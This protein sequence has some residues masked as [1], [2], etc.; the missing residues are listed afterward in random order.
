[1]GMATTCRSGT[2][3]Q[4]NISSP[5]KANQLPVPAITSHRLHGHPMANALRSPLIKQ[6]RSGMLPQN[7]CYSPIQLV[8]LH[9]LLMADISLRR[10]AMEQFK[11][12]MRKHI[13]PSMSTKVRSGNKEYRPLHGRPMAHASLLAV[14]I[15]TYGMQLPE[16]MFSSIKGTG[17][18]NILV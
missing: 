11:Y 10:I 1:M 7:T 2:P 16:R 8:V 18:V 6:S 14:Q 3:L 12:G 5:Y 13:R 15:Y 9:G 17:A 4:E